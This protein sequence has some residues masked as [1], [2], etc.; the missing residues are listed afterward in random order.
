MPIRDSTAPTVTLPQQPILNFLN[1]KLHQGPR[2]NSMLTPVKAWTL[3]NAT[4]VPLTALT[5]GYCVRVKKAGWPWAAENQA[6]SHMGTMKNPCSSL[7][8]RSNELPEFLP[9]LL[10]N[11]GLWPGIAS[12]IKPFF[13]K[14]FSVQ[15]FYHGT[16]PK[17]SSSERLT[18]LPW[19]SPWNLFQTLEQR[20]Y[21]GMFRSGGGDYWL[22]QLQW[23][24]MR[25]NRKGPWVLRILQCDG[26]SYKT[27]TFPHPT[28]PSNSR[29]RN[30]L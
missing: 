1:Q 29:V 4:K 12:Q 22:S 7:Q 26:Q 6:S 18:S 14:L 15:I 19:T 10:P 17:F 24:S 2:E 27:V 9:W 25:L 11:G 8:V 5:T 16:G 28:Q 13:P 20:F 30:C 3:S 21:M 23:V